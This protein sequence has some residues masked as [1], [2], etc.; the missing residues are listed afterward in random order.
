MGESSRKT[1]QTFAAGEATALAGKGLM[2]PDL[3]R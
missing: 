3:T 1:G 2:I